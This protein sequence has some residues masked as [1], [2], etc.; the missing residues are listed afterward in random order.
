MISDEPAELC[1]KV[2]ETVESGLSGTSLDGAQVE[3]MA[4]EEPVHQMAWYWKAIIRQPFK[5][6]GCDLK[7]FIGVTRSDLIRQ[8]TLLEQTA[9]FMT[10]A[11]MLSAVLVDEFERHSEPAKAAADHA[12]EMRSYI[13]MNEKE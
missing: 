8:R 2:K 11:E 7:T 12:Q 5:E 1:R 13:R 9:L 4:I 10:K 3:I 6:C